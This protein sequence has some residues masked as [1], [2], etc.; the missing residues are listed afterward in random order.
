MTYH[1]VTKNT[2]HDNYYLTDTISLD[3]I[4]GTSI[5]IHR[6][7]S[8]PSVSPWYYFGQDQRGSAGPFRNA[9]IAPISGFR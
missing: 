3:F 6:R 2:E 9:T 7:L 8:V 1:G 5:V 4:R